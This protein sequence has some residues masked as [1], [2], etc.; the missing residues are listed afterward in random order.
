MQLLAK[1]KS[2]ANTELMMLTQVNGLV[3]TA[4]QTESGS[5]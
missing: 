2:Q 3:F 1:L 5:L 4:W